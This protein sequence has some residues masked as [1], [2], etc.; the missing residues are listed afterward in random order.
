M[1]DAIVPL[2]RALPRT[3]EDLDRLSQITADDLEATLATMPDT[4]RAFLEAEPDDGDG[5]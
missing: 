2:G 3:D 5:A 4:V 1:P